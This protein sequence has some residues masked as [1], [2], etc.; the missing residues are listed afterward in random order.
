M[1]LLQDIK[2]YLLFNQVLS[3]ACFWWSCTVR[4]FV[5]NRGTCLSNFAIEAAE[6]RSRE[7][8]SC[9]CMKTLSVPLCF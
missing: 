1:M 8:N 4:Y 5:H 7:S 6:L 2:I 9:C 3:T